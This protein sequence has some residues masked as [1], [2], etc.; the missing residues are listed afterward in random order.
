MS[1][2]SKIFPEN[3]FFRS[4]LNCRSDDSIRQTRKERGT[5]TGTDGPL[6]VGRDDRAIGGPD[7]TVLT[8]S[9]SIRRVSVLYS[10]LM[11]KLIAHPI[12]LFVCHD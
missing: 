8:W 7:F 12:N 6:A 11:I 4:Y 1:D 3:A 10:V 2:Q 5:G 9:A